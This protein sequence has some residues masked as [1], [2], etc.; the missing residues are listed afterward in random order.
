ML[1]T[2]QLDQS[3]GT[4]SPATDLIKFFRFV[5]GVDWRKYAVTTHGGG[6]LLRRASL[7]WN[8]DLDFISIQHP[9]DACTSA[10]PLGRADEP[11]EGHLLARF[12][13]LP[14]HR[15]FFARSQLPFVVLDQL[16]IRRF[17][18]SRAGEEERA[19]RDG[20]LE[21]DVAAGAPASTRAVGGRIATCAVG[22]FSRDLAFTGTNSAENR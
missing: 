14:H 9:V 16:V 5:C 11:S 7:G 13:L 19:G 21:R 18:P 15:R 22:R 17:I 10:P 2:R 12:T 8:D 6:G 3:T 4:T 1:T 20:E